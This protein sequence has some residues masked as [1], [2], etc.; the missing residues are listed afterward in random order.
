MIKVLSLA[1]LKRE[2]PALLFL[3]K[4]LILLC[5][6]KSI[7]FFYN[8]AAAGG[9]KITSMNDFF[10]VIGWSFCY[11]ILILAIINFPF[12]LLLLVLPSRWMAAKTYWFLAA[13]FVIFNSINLLLNFADIFYFRYHLQRADADLLYVL[14]N[15]FKENNLPSIAIGLGLIVA[16]AFCSWLLRKQYKKIE[17]A[18]VNGTKFFISN[19]VL[20]AFLLLFSITGTKK[21]LPTYPLTTISAT[22]LNLVQNSV[23]SL[24]FSWFRRNDAVIYNRKYMPQAEQEKL[25]SYHKQNMQPGTKRNVVLFIM[26]SIPEEFFNIESRYKV[27]MP[28][29]DSLLTKSTYFSNAYSY[30]HHSNK[31]ITAILA[32][33]PTLTEIPLYHSSYTN[34]PVTQIGHRLAKEGYNSSFFIGDHY[35]DFGFAKCCNWLGINYFS[36][37]DLPGNSGMAKNAMGVH[38]EY[39]LDFMKEKLDAEKGNFFA[40]NYNTST[41]YPSQLPN[42]YHD[43]FLKQNFTG[44]MQ[45]MAYYSNC[46]QQFFTSAAKEKWFEN[47]VFIFCSDHWMYPDMNNQEM[48]MLQSFHIPLFIYDPQNENKKIIMRPVSQLDIINSV[49]QYSGSNGDFVSYGSNLADS[50]NTNRIVF[51]KETSILYQAIDSNYILGFN[52][53]LGRPEYLF[54]HKKDPQRKNNLLNNNC[55]ARAAILTKTMEAFLQ[56][57]YQHYG[58][59]N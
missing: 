45:S 55:P 42:Q 4:L 52:A 49:I 20:A 9:W 39:V 31:G 32:G 25:F 38:D 7:F 51:T 44:Q 36:M 13:I 27:A 33:I 50:T 5:L 22:Q 58:F 21:F 16:F 26:E 23:H 37:E 12:F 43:P 6:F 41:H 1:N 48:D 2:K 10:K 8:A 54:E 18:S 19:L 14:K 35:D 28:F 47:T 3:L 11:D 57:A 17:T 46:L 34:I 24:A 29:V 56:A 30:A 15:P 40:V 53:V 59:K